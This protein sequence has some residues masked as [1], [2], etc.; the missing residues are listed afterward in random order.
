[1]RSNLTHSFHTHT[2]KDREIEEEEDEDP[3]DGVKYRL[4][5]RFG[6]MHLRGYTWKI[7]AHE[8]EKNFAFFYF[9][10]DKSLFVAQLEK[11][12][13]RTRRLASGNNEQS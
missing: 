4:S 12:I 6:G 3:G 9:F 10:C 1:M 13:I 8:N 11:I 2:Q 7:L 5:F